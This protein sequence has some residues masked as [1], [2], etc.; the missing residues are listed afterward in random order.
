[1]V[2]EGRVL[3]VGRSGSLVQRGGRYE[4][5]PIGRGSSLSRGQ[6]RN[7]PPLRTRGELPMLRERCNT[8]Q[9]AQ[10]LINGM[11]LASG[12]ITMCS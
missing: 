6:E 4:S 12:D 10:S 9:I 7:D 8:L 2:V 3:F 1:M 11:Y 5:L